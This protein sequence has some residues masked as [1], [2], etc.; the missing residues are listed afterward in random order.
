MLA[1]HLAEFHSDGMRHARPKGALDRTTILSA[2]LLD[3]HA[4][5]IFQQ[6]IQMAPDGEP[7][8]LDAEGVRA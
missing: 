4:E 7:K 2:R 3:H 8:A 6:G 5:E 1:P